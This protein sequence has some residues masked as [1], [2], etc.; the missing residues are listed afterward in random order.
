MDGRRLRFFRIAF[1]LR[2]FFL[3]VTLLCVGLGMLSNSIHRQRRAVS[4]I[5]NAGG[6][7]WISHDD[8]WWERIIG[9][10]ILGGP[11]QVEFSTN[12]AV[13]GRATDRQVA[14]VGELNSTEYLD[15][16]FTDASDGAMEFI[17]RCR[18]LKYLNLRETCVTDEGMLHL[19]SL[20][21][22]EHL[23]L[24]G[25]EV[26]DRALAYVAGLKKLKYIGLSGTKVTNAG[27]QH[28]RG[29]Y[30][31]E[32]F[33]VDHTHVCATSDELFELFKHLPQLRGL[34]TNF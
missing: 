27:L 6:W 32:S 13:P 10:E 11:Y 14:V 23:D 28:L 9:C 1:S 8:N 2:A 17:G 16:S 33:A 29:L 30:S 15:A 18:H 5:E 19:R 26:G 22:L 21:L 34:Y 7:A 12:P 25:T 20:K 31:L 4:I 24:S 3:V